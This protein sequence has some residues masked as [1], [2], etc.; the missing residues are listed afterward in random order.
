MSTFLDYVSR[1]YRVS[2][3]ALLPIF[4]TVQTIGR[5]RQLDPLL[6]VAIIGIESRFNP[7]S[8]S[9][10]GALGLMQ[11]ISRFHIEKFPVG[12]EKGDLRDPVINVKGSSRF[13][14]NN[15]YRLCSSIRHET[16]P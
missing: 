1:R 4:R 13:N 15:C 16:G 10:V 14:L 6:I 11:V 9:P 3:E 8:E 12:A 2:S 7:F 5:E